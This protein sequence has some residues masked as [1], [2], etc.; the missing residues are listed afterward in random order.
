MPD[1]SCYTRPSEHMVAV[2][3]VMSVFEAEPPEALHSDSASHHVVLPH[4]V[5]EAITS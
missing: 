4:R 5:L 3:S 1:K 2:F